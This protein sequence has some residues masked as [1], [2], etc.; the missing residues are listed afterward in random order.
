MPLTRVNFHGV[1]IYILKIILREIIK[2][3][4]KKSDTEN[5]TNIFIFQDSNLDL[6]I[7]NSLN[8]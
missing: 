1:E 8:Q 7:E 2:K 6:H 3:K 5:S 4:T